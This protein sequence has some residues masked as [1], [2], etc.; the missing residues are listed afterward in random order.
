MMVLQDSMDSQRDV[1]GSHSEA[2]ASSL[3]G[4]QAVNIKV[5]EFSDIEDGEG[6]VPMT[7]VEIK[8]EHEVSFMSLRPMLGTSQ[9][10]PELP[11]RFLICIFHTK[12]FRS[13]E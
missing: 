10:H 2:C 1:P 11:V 9:S 13:S 3:D 8:A 7:V 5:E 12:I 4:V 6:P